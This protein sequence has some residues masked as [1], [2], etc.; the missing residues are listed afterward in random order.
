MKVCPACNTQILPGALACPCGVLVHAEELKTLH[1]RAKASREQGDLEEAS[2]T[3]SRCLALLPGNTRQYQVLQ[4]D[5]AAVKQELAKRPPPDFKPDEPFVQQSSIVI[6][7]KGLFRPVTLVTCAMWVGLAHA[8]LGWSVTQAAL[9]AVLLYFHEL[10]HILVL[11]RLSI[12]FSYP[13]FVPLMGAFVL[14]RNTGISSRD[15]VLIS[16]GGPALGTLV[17]AVIIGLHHLYRPLPPVLLSTAEANAVINGMNLLPFWA[18]DGGR[19][20]DLSRRGHILLGGSLLVP[21]GLLNY[22]GRLAWLMWL[23]A[24]VFAGRALFHNAIPK[25]GIPENAEPAPVWA[26]LLSASLLGAAVACSGLV[27]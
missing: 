20:A 5:L 17:S 18:L 16:L 1:A 19:I 25:T 27:S 3:L 24:I 6:L 10:G 14:H 2:L 23:C 22:P 26:A 15:R 9:F 4:Q 13:V 12:P 8:L 7:L 11:N 21:L